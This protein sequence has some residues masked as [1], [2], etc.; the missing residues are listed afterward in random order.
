M[1][2]AFR[3]CKDQRRGWFPLRRR[4]HRGGH[5]RD[6]ITPCRREE[7][8]PAVQPART[9]GVEL[10]D[11]TAL[12]VG[13]LKVRRTQVERPTLVTEFLGEEVSP[14]LNSL[15]REFR[16]P[17]DVFHVSAKLFTHGQTS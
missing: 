2:L 13:E 15:R 4:S 9:R 1:A 16:S 8:V 11:D 6:L 3:L 10:S 5:G 14:A 17:F 7:S 12:G